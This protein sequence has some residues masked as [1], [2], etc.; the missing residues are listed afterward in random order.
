MTAQV[1]ELTGP[2]QFQLSECEVPAPGPGQVQVR[3]EAVGICGSDVHAYAEGGVGDSS[4]IYPMVLGHEPAGAVIQVGAGVSGWAPGDRAAFEPAIYCYH[5]EYCRT[6]HHNVCSNIRFMSMPGEPGFLREYANLPGGNL[7]AIP[8]HLTAG[9]ASLI[10]PLAVALHSLNLA[11]LGPDETVAVFGAGPIGLLTIICLKLAG[12]A[13]VW[14]IEPVAGRRALALDA[15]ADAVLDPAACE[16]A[17]EILRDTAGR[18]VDLSI[19]CAAKGGSVNQC[20]HA[21]R[22]AGRVVITGI[23]AEPQVA[24]EFSPLRR[25]EISIY[26]VR[27]SNQ[28]T[29]AARHLLLSHLPRFAA[30][31]TH[32]LPLARAGAAFAQAEIAGDGAGK[33]LI[34]PGA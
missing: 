6:G 15:G 29:P 27:R 4:C 2:R 31:I 25:K 11:A 14:A 26:P 13:R 24:L 32:S 17:R 30:I 23:P 10:E 8:S 7:L 20:L 19:D 21:T 3:I 22:N 34:L 5:C 18:G 12:A 33:I 16:P 1:A 9:E 28:E